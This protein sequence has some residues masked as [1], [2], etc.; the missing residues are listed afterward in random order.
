M[1]D[2]LHTDELHR[3]TAGICSILSAELGT[4]M[5]TEH[6]GGRVDPQGAEVAR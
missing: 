3:L 5:F 2:R 1:Q 6:P 4:S